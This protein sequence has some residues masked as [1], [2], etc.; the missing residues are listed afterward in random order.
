MRTNLNVRSIRIRL[1]Q[2]CSEGD[3]YDMMDGAEKL[4]AELKKLY[5]SIRLQTA[6]SQ[7]ILRKV[8]DLLQLMRVCL[9]EGG[10]EFDVEAE[11]SRLRM[12]LD[13]EYA[14]FVYG[15]AA[16]SVTPCSC[17]QSDHLSESPS[18]SA[19]RAETAAQLAAKRAEINMEAAIEAQRQQ[20]NK[21]ENQSDLDVIQAKLNVYIE[22]ETKGKDGSCSPVHSKVDDT[23]PLTHSIPGQEQPAVKN[24]TS[25][26]QALQESLALPRLPTPEP[27]VFSGDPL[28]FTEWSSN[29][30]ALIER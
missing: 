3:M 21:L 16:S 27:A 29:F 24:E 30:K 11:R 22:E 25:L 17:H 26:V 15:S 9:T 5:D 19:K 20:L 6:P 23:S 8:S 10:G 13:N 4:D 2:E 14:R 1:K 7:E 12:L 28:K 18:I